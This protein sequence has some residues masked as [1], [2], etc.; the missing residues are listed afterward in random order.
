MITEDQ[1]EQLCLAWF[2][3]QAWDYAYGPDIVP[4]GD[5]PERREYRQV[6][7][8]DHAGKGDARFFDAASP[9]CWNAP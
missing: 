3:D 4:D 6:V 9:G 2:R 7:L 8:R 5:S 1:L